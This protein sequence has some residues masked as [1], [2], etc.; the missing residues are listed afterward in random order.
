MKRHL[1]ILLFLILPF[2]VL[3]Q[4]SEKP[5]PFF[6]GVFQ[7]PNGTSNFAFKKLM[8]GVSDLALSLN[9]PIGE[10]FHAGFVFEHAYF[11]FDDLSIPER[12]NAT[13]QIPGG[14][15]TFGYTI[16]SSEKLNVEFAM[17]AG[18]S[19]M[20]TSSETCFDAN[21]KKFYIQNGLH[22]RPNVGF[23]L[24]TN[25]YLSFGL[26]LSYSIYVS[27]FSPDNL[28]IPEFSGYQNS[29]YSGNY[30]M[31]AVGFGF[32]TSLSSRK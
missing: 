3:S 23:Y 6:K 2:T 1:T 30:Q 11:T 14:S 8:G 25:E 21:G 22:L 18:Y 17:N 29:D 27:E 28:C 15:L 12:T 16:P 24:V 31:F 26:T 20:L 32:R 9:F 5:K 7:L 10:R 4:K 19:Y 13:M